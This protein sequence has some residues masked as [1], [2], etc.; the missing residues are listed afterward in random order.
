MIMCLP[1]VRLLIHFT[2]LFI[3]NS[4]GFWGYG[5]YASPGKMKAILERFGG[6]HALHVALAMQAWQ[7]RIVHHLLSGVSS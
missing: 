4:M 5:I 1:D 6:F 2:L 3:K 7:A